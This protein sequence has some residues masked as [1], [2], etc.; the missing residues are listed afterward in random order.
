MSMPTASFLRSRT[1]GRAST[2]RFC[3]A[4]LGALVLASCA[5]KVGDIDRTQPNLLAKTMFLDHAWFVRQTVTDVPATSA[6][7]FVGETG[8]LEIVRW[9]IQ[10]SYLVGYRAYEKVPGSDS[11]AD[12]STAEVGKQ[13]VR[14]G[15]GSGRQPD[16]FKGNPIVAYPILEHV[17]VIRD[18]NAR[19]GE[20]TNVIREDALDRPWYERGHVRVDW[21]Q[22]LVAS[23]DFISGA[24][25]I[26][27]TNT[28]FVEENEGGADAFKKHLDSTGG[29]DYFDFTER[30]FVEP[31]E[32]GCILSQNLQLGDCTGDE[33][34]V[35]TSFLRVDEAREQDYVPEAYDDKRQGEFGYFRVER[36]TYD[37][38]RGVTWS[39]A[40]LL[41]SKHDVWKDSRDGAGEAKPVAERGLR[42]ITYTLSPNYPQELS[43]VTT[44]MAAEWDSALK[45]GIATA[46]KQTVA[47]LEADL[48]AQTGGTCLYCIDLNADGHARIGDLRYNFIYWV[49]HP[50]LAGPL[51]YGP[52]SPNPETG[53]I[54]SGAA[55]VYGASV[56][57]QAQYGQDIVELLNGDRTPLDLL[58]AKFIREQ[59][60]GRKP[61]IAASKAS[62][63]AR[64]KAEPGA[65]L[66]KG[67]RDRVE[68]VRR[69]GLPPAHRGRDTA[70]LAQIRGT[71]LERMLINDEVVI[72][73]GRGKYS[74]TA[75]LTDAAVKELSPLQWGTSD[76]QQKEGRRRD[77]ASERCVWLNDFDDP[78]VIGLAKSVK[79]AGLK[80]DALW[81]RLRTDIYRGVML[82]EIGHTLGLRHNFGASADALNYKPEYWPL[83]TR[84]IGA[85]PP[86]TVGDILER[87][88]EL[89]NEDNDEACTA[90]RDG[91]MIE[92]QYSSVMDYGAK[93]NSDIHGLGHY[94]RAAIAA[95][96]GDLVQ[97]FA[98]EVSAQ[99]RESDRALVEDVADIRIPLDGSLTELVHYTRLPQIF[100][101]IES[102]QKRRYI[103]R[104]QYEMARATDTA[105]LR[106]PYIA[107]YD[108][109]VDATPTCHRWDQGADPYEITQQY[110]D[111]YREYY[112]LVNLQRD[113]IGFSPA[114]V[115]NRI[116]ERYFLPISNMYQQ[117][118]F[119]ASSGGSLDNMLDVYSELGM[120][121]G[122]SLLWDV[123]STP[124]YGSYK[125]VEGS[126][127]WMGYAERTDGS[128]YLPPGPGRREFS[129]YDRSAGYNFYQHVLEAGFFYEQIGALSALTASDASLLGIGADVDADQLAYSI[130]YYIVFQEEIDELFAGLISEDYKTYGPKVTDGALV[131]KDLWLEQFEDGPD[132]SPSL[133]VS[134]SWSTRLYTMLY[135][136]ALLSSNFDASF[137]RKAQV[138]V[139][140]ESETVTVAKNF[141]EVRGV[142]PISGRTY[143][144]YEDPKGDP[145]TFLGAKLVKKLEAL[146]TQYLA[147]ASGDP[148]ADELRSEIQYQVETLE[149]L[150]SLY[151]EYQYV[152]SGS[153][154]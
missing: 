21:S 103:P 90:M 48:T 34:K 33:V 58:D 30:M 98:D 80:G 137:L 62:A 64:V 86:E 35:R 19:T 6:F 59:V 141:V 11:K 135:G 41:I 126:Y 43:T 130:P 152:F 66:S 24:R 42:P 144:A 1:Q 145:N 146:G 40:Q 65:L 123:M 20:Q 102:L 68:N 69:T 106:V 27:P 14:A 142:D 116:T 77:K 84:N 131:T 139:V 111:T 91:R 120:L 54:V 129:R 9:E 55:Y 96:Y 154:E 75:P 107:C 104:K 133:E 115:G 74:L 32:D 15:Q 82:H 60:N 51:G 85:E 83:R 71:P 81:Q 18:Y 13:P 78:G 10:Q 110:V 4:V 93:F 5:Q 56:D 36:P 94:D 76:A 127:R 38:R 23:F 149:I 105:P 46:R 28:G 70:R 100:G 97:V 61:K 147:L 2:L 8:T 87:A 31:S 109:F 117:W 44:Q 63:L 73:Q 119:S 92:H 134:T 45:D 72:G 148:A 52:S 121:R 89:V 53:R 47:Q 67:Q 88:C 153:A 101:G 112:P 140:G 17:D 12:Q 124:R 99:M 108:E 150:R 114:A 138:A 57:T 143:A 122:F 50:Q 125:L 49:D 113:R 37:R 128:L 26:T 132:P 39:G 118:L 16:V 136:S 7:S 29:V 95:G 151:V 22:N 79:A 3:L 25:S